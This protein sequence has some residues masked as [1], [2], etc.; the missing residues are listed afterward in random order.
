MARTTSRGIAVVLSRNHAATTV[1]INEIASTKYGFAL[2][3]LL[4]DIALSRIRTLVKPNT[5]PEHRDG[6]KRGGG[7]ASSGRSTG[8]GHICRRKVRG[9]GRKGPANP[10]QSACRD[11]TLRKNL[12]GSFHPS[13]F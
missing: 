1:R 12:E 2:C 7:C 10:I 3:L 9:R 11:N 4:P 5:N 6:R 8:R 13:A